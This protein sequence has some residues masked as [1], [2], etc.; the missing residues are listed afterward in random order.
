MLNSLISKESLTAFFEGASEALDISETLSQRAED[1]YKA[2]G[3]WLERAESTVVKFQPHI[4]P[5]GSIALGTVIRPV[6][7][8]DEYDVDVVCVVSLAKSS[9]TQER[10]KHLVGK[11][12]ADYAKANSMI[13]PVQE[14]KRC[15]T[16]NYADGAQFHMDILPGIPEGGGLKL[17]LES[18]QISNEWVQHAISITDNTSRTYSQLTDKWPSS[19]P[20]G[21]ALWFRERM[22]T[23]YDKRRKILAEAVRGKIEDVPEYKIKTP[24]QRAVQILKR[25]RD[26]MFVKDLENKPISII[27]ST[28][29]AHAYN[30][31]DNVADALYNIVGRMKQ[32]VENRNGEGWVA[33]PVNP[34]ENFADKWVQYPKRKENFFYWLRQV[35]NDFS[36]AVSIA[37]GI[38]QLANTLQPRLGSRIINEAV[39]HTN[40]NLASKNFINKT[41]DGIKSLFQVP[42]CQRL[43]WTFRPQFLAEISGRVSEKGSWRSFQSNCSALPK[44]CSL[45]FST[46]TNAPEPYDVYWQVVNTGEEASRVN[47]LRGKIFPAKAAGRGG[48]IQDEETSYTG[49]HWIECFIVK[50]GV[51]VARSGEYVVNIA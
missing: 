11:E 22:K 33:N 2:I 48:L 42:H 36:T 12:V 39:E 49:A 9:I 18:R 35:E 5:Q 3:R 14:G 41:I 29:A 51:C 21:Y 40:K 28:L 37:G 20:K 1:K 26:I 32:F 19:N 8:S 30:N 38:Q 4:Y 45:S 6:N 24:L 13:N 47:Q 17:L 43:L 16:L 27:I 15:W 7:D 23:Q 46:K 25:H 34:L 31:E 50:D 44:G 10:L